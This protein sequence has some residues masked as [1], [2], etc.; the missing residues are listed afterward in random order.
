MPVK[1]RDS[2]NINDSYTLPATDG[3]A[4]QVI[5]T[6]G[7]GNLSFTNQSG[8]SSTLNVEK[9]I[10][11]GN[12]SATAFTVSS[13]I[14][15]ENNT[16]IY[17]DGVYQ[18]KDNY[19]T[20]GTTV[21]FSTAPPNGAE[22]E[23]IHYVSVQGV[24]KTDKSTADG[25]NTAFTSSLTILDENNTQVYIDGVYQ[26]KDNYTTSGNIV[27]LSTAPGNGAIVEIVHIKAS[28]V[29]TIAGDQFTG[30]GSTTAFTLSK[31]IEDEN[32]T[33][34]FINGVYQ[35][36]TMYSI[37]GTT[38]TFS[39]APQSGY[40]IEVMHFTTISLEAGATIQRGTTAQRP[41]S[42]IGGLTRW[43]TTTLKLE[44]WNGTAWYNIG[45]DY[46]FTTD[47]TT[48]TADIATLTAD[49]TKR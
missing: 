48:I 39:T 1:F 34:V 24:I 38:L 12:G 7:S 44:V 35:E 28:D 36:K 2:I 42:P 8:G 20:S 33:F 4:D 41:S 43:N 11:T 18:S 13:T 40:S 10:L 23:V 14:A 32:T 45:P 16:Q 22:I 31:N 26:S 37:S 25:S 47:I 6:D 5:K 15:S 46:P 9:N 3:S 29:S 30:N 21:T 17:I 19:S 49:S 27:T